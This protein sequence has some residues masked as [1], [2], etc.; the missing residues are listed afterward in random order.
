[1]C[2]CLQYKN[3]LVNMFVKAP[4]VKD[5]LKEEEELDV[6]KCPVNR[7]EFTVLLPKTFPSIH[8]EKPLKWWHLDEKPVR[9]RT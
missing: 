5:A 6:L 7:K 3:A 8:H 2:P 4:V 1:M 9:E